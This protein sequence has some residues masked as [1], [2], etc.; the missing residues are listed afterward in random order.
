M[1]QPPAAVLA[2]DVGNSKTDL[3]LLAA[4]GAL[5]AAVRGPTAS[6]QA[7]GLDGAM[8]SLGEAVAAACR[9]AGL[10]PEQRPV[11]T[12]GVHCAA[13]VDFPRDERRLAAALATLGFATRDLVLNDTRA[14]LRAGSRRGWGIGVVCGAGINA[15]GLAPDG[16]IARFDAVGDISG[17]WG[18]GGA[19]GRAALAAAI[20][21]R[22]R[23][24]PRTLLERTV[25]AHFGL[26]RPGSVTAAMYDGR[27][28]EARVGELAPVVFAAAAAGDAVAVAILDRLADEI[29]A[30]VVSLMRRLHL[31]RLDPDVCL[32]GGIFRAEAPA[33]LARIEA[34]ARVVGPRARVVRV[35]APP[36]LGAA[37]LGLDRLSP[38][39]LTPVPVEDDLRGCLTLERLMASER[40]TG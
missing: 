10:D 31:T 40:R 39:G 2:A 14:A 27:L 4:D 3:A 5:L 12:L 33:F 15:V 22:D 30:W 20:R 18:G 26:T 24:G 21:G 8:V 38:Q 25:P 36:V 23:R 37:L 6:H 17:D 34:G 28:A 11:A 35:T 9:A 32:A 1:T 19:I 13:G 7:V 16:R 29:V